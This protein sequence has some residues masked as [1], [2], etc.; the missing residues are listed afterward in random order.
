MTLPER[1]CF[2]WS[3]VMSRSRGKDFYKWTASCRHFLTP[4]TVVRDILS[5][6]WKSTPY[7]KHFI[8]NHSGRFLYGWQ[9][10]GSFLFLIRILWLFLQ[11]ESWL[12]IIRM[13]RLPFLSP[14]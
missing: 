7:E 13:N 6:P 2:R 11:G 4:N 12:S 5:E 3:M 10:V 14:C 1:D 8:A 9:M